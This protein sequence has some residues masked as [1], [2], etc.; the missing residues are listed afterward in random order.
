MN[1]SLPLFVSRETHTCLIVKYF[2]HLQSMVG[3]WVWRTDRCQTMQHI[4]ET[5]QPANIGTTLCIAFPH[6]LRVIIVCPDRGR[7]YN[8]TRL[9]IN[10][11]IYVRL[12]KKPHNISSTRK[13]LQASRNTSIAQYLERKLHII[14]MTWQI[15]EVIF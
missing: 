13:Y 15:K 8:E 7:Q 14:N 11:W 1:Q 5:V 4:L 12:I 6:R 2:R 9:L 3:L 10:F